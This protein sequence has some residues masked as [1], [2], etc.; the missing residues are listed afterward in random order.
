[1]GLVKPYMNFSFDGFKVCLLNKAEFIDQ[2]V[3]YDYV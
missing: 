3:I 1:M 2:S